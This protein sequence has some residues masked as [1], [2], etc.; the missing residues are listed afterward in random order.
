MITETIQVTNKQGLHL[1]LASLLVAEMRKFK[2]S[3]TMDYGG[4]KYDGK[5]IINILMACIP[6]GSYIEVIADG[7]DEQEVLE[8][9]KK[10]VSDNDPMIDKAKGRG[11]VHL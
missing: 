3:V 4:K 10:L 8:Q 11:S 5:S 9:F 1:G 6:C 2:S 7:E